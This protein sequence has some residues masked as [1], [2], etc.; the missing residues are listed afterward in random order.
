M[1]LITISK[2]DSFRELT[3]RPRCD[4]T[5][6]GELLLSLIE[7]S[8][9][10]PMMSAPRSQMPWRIL[11]LDDEPTTLAM[12]SNVLTNDGWQTLPARN[13]RDASSHLASVVPDAAI[14]DVFLGGE[15][16]LEYVTSL[17]QR[18][19]NMGIVVISLEDTE[20]LAQKAIASG[21]DYFLSKPIA[22][23]ALNLTLNK[24]RELRIHRQRTTDLE[25]E[26]K[27][28]N[29]DI[30]F[31]EILTH[32]DSMKSVLRLIEK[33]GSRDL[34]VLIFG[35][36]GTGKELVARALHQTSSRSAGRFVELNCAALPANLVESE[37]F[38]H[39]KGAFTGA[40]TARAG[41]IELAHR[42]TLFLDEIGE[43]PLEIQP[44]LLRALQEKKVTRVGGKTDIECDFRLI[45]ATHRDLLQEVR[46]G[47]FRED[48]FYRIAVFPVKLPPLRD[49]L[50]DLELLLFHFLEQEGVRNARLTSEA[51]LLLGGYQ[52]PGNV[53]ELKNFAQ[54]A[55]LYSERGIIDEFVVRQYFGTRLNDGPGLRPAPNLYSGGIQTP[56]PSGRPVKKLE[57]LERQEILYALRTYRGNVPEA[58]LALGMGRATLYK[59]IKKNEIKLSQFE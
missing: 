30:L 23:T 56:L 34:S 38:G 13:T 39:E 36:S 53:R 57:D 16:G 15:D 58:A 11:V 12:L 54:A 48:L 19:P 37:L 14:V 43:L 55:T 42:G 33:V 51:Q 49:R 35:E 2:Q 26:L 47:T 17:R 24:V 5:S 52:W 7:D 31:P 4:V 18:F 25:K 44:K 41:R 22:P 27:K 10:C 40:L 32:S 46:K 20:S 1:P 6:L 9:D 3:C 29:E 21:A 50:E 28:R 59:Y 8:G 45:S